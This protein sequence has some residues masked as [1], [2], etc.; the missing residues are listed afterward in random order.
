M[1]TNLSSFSQ[2]TL[3][4]GE[5]PVKVNYQGE[6]RVLITLSQVDS[7]NITYSYLDECR[8]YSDTLETVVLEFHEIIE[9]GKVAE[10]Q[11]RKVINSKN[12]I[13]DKSNELVFELE[14]EIAKKEK[15]MKFLKLTTSILGGI[16]AVLLIV[17]LL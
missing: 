5:F 9:E 11:L 12:D 4:E 16:A 13:L 10:S 17:V 7:L 14:N 2:Q 15:K 6:Q 3:Q 1:M 8:E